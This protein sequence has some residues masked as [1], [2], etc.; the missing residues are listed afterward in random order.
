MASLHTY[1]I[2]VMGTAFTAETP[3]R[4]AQYGI[5]SVIALADDVLLERLRKIYS[6]RYNLSYS[7]LFTHESMNNEG[8]IM[9]LN[10][11]EIY[12]IDTGKFTGRSPKDKWIVKNINSDSLT[13]SSNVCVDLLGSR[14]YTLTSASQPTFGENPN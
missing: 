9:K 3:L 5:N 12:S 2:P 10:N 1:H 6:E 4:V 8:E 14:S 7:E 11:D 13:V